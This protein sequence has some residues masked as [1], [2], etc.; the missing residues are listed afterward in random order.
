MPEACAIIALLATP[1]GKERQPVVEGDRIRTCH[2]PWYRG[3]RRAGTPMENVSLFM[4]AQEMY[5]GV[6]CILD[7]QLDYA[8]GDVERGFVESTRGIKVGNDLLCS[9][10]S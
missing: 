3:V 1:G 7:L 4:L 2:V 10:L 5:Q 9:I 8:K 6:L